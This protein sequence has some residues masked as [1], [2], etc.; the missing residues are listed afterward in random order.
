MDCAAFVGGAFE[1]AQGGGADGDDPPAPAP[2]PVD[3]RRRAPAHHAALGLHAVMLGVGD[4]HRSEGAGADVQGDRRLADAA[5]AEPGDQAAREVEA[6]GGRRHR[7]GARRVDGLVVAAVAGVGR[8]LA[9][10]IGRQRHLAVTGQRLLQGAGAEREAEPHLAALALVDDLRREIGAEADLVARP[11]PPRRPCQ[12][13]PPPRSELLEQGHLDLSLAAPAAEPR[14]RHPGVV[15]HHHVP[16]LEQSGQVADPAL[17]EALAHDQE[18][19][20]IARRRGP[21]GDQPARQLEVE[22]VDLHG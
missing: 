19:R 21:A 14:R 20:R 18:S 16:G 3:R 22:G 17:V 13:A 11:Q 2:R 1:Q 15:P 12:G 7:P 9:Q 6:R 5:L 4:L 10:D 8:A